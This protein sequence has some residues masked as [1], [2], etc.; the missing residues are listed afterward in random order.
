MCHR[1][2]GRNDFARCRLPPNSKNPT[3]ACR[4]ERAGGQSRC[5]ARSL[6][7]RG[8]L[9]DASSG[10]KSSSPVLSTES[11]E[12]VSVNRDRVPL[13]RSG[14]PAKKR[15]VT[16]TH[17]VGAG[18]LLCIRVAALRASEERA[19]KT[20]RWLCRT[21]GSGDDDAARVCVATITAAASFL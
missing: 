15:R 4:A 19:P 1:P 16:E 11:V 7:D 13:R 18:D 10:P 9:P 21:G 5:R 2:E 6:L 14:A 17:T 20:R 12:T 8:K 3:G